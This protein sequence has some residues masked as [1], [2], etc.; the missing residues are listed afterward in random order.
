MSHITIYFGMI[1]NAGKRGIVELVHDQAT[2]LYIVE[3]V[4]NQ[5]TVLYIVELVHNEAT[6][7]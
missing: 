3:L 1:L 6:V 4:H 2:V 5:A 7:L